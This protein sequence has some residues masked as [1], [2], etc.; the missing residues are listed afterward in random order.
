MMSESA[1]SE[2]PSSVHQSKEF[3]SSMDIRGGKGKMSMSK[4][5]MRTKSNNFGEDKGTNA[6]FLKKCLMSIKEL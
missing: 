5:I 4:S 6:D 3:R 2:M 1:D